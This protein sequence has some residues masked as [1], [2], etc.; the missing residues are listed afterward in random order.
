[1]AVALGLSNGPTATAGASQAP[2][3]HAASQT[4]SLPAAGGRGPATLAASA[5]H[6]A[7]G[8]AEPPGG[9][10]SMI[11]QPRFSLREQMER[12][13][14]YSSQALATGG[15]QVVG[16]GSALACSRPGCYLPLASWLEC[17]RRLV[18][19][20]TLLRGACSLSALLGYQHVSTLRCSPLLPLPARR[21]CPTLSL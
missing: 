8:S 9:A 13:E 15:P 16:G 20:R 14:K 17:P 5:A 12:L 1:M 7:G 11:H 6:A 21:A 10:A 19:L 2:S 3:G 18:A 4:T